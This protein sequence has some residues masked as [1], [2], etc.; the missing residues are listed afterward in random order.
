MWEW[1]RDDVLGLEHAEVKVPVG[2]L[3]TDIELA[4]RYIDPDLKGEVWAGDTG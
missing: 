2:H 4:I 3:S 1:E